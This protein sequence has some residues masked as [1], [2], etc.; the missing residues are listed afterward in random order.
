MSHAFVDAITKAYNNIDFISCFEK[1]LVHTDFLNRLRK[2]DKKEVL[3]NLKEL[4]YTFQV[5]RQGRNILATRFT[6]N[7]NFDSSSM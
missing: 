3:R 1:I 6:V 7:S 5:R 4:G 2:T